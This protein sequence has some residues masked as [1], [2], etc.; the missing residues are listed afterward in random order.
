MTPHR[1]RRLALSSMAVAVVA[2]TVAVDHR[3]CRTGDDWSRYDHRSYRVTVDAGDQV[4]LPDGTPVAL[5]G[6]ADPIP[7]ATDWLT[8]AIAG[9]PVTLL[10]PALGTRDASHRLLAHVYLPDNGCLNVAIVHEGLAYAD[11]RGADVFASMINAAEADARRK[12]RGLWDGLRFE[13]MPAWRQAWLRR[14]ATSHPSK[15]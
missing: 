5:I 1:R 13:Q 9:R 15:H 12:Q 7:A 11:R 14:R 10:L 4:R 2:A 6:V 3:W 8:R